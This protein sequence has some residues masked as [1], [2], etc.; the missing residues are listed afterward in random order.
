MTYRRW[1]ALGWALSAAVAATGC[2][3][4]VR[5]YGEFC[6]TSEV[7]GSSHDLVVNAN[8]GDCASDHKGAEFRCEVEQDEQGDVRVTTFF[9]DG[10]DPND[11]C[12]PPLFAECRVTVVAGEYQVF[13]ADDEVAVSVPVI[14]PTCLPEGTLPEE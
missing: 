3:D 13:F 7:N 11:A 8:S 10:N 9:T 12:A 1:F 14:A 2:Y 6:L 4:E 5:D